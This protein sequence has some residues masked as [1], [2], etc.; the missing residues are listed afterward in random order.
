MPQSGKN[1]LHYNTRSELNPCFTTYVQTGKCTL[2]KHVKI[3]TEDCIIENTCIIIILTVV[4]I[5]HYKKYSDVF[6]HVHVSSHY[7]GWVDLRTCSDSI[8]V[9]FIKFTLFRHSYYCDW[10]II[11]FD[12]FLMKF[13]PNFYSVILKILKSCHYI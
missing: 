3:L 4:I 13:Q 8:L 6:I 9:S 2:F 11:K 1:R 10:S 5:I 12:R 7:K